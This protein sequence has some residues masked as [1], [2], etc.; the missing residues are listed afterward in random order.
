MSNG[1]IKI[2]SNHDFETT[3][4]RLKKVLEDNPM[5]GI[6]AELDHQKNAERVDLS[7]GK[8]RIIMFGNPRLGTPLMQTNINIAIDLPQK[9]VVFEGND[10]TVYIAFNDPIYLKERH[11]VEGKDEVF[12]KIS[13]ALNKLAGAAAN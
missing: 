2:K 5:I 7:L 6:V 10:E 13:G 11:G 3:Y 12:A 8:T 9:F 1:L 4:S